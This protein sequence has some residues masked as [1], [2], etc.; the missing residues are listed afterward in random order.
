MILVFFLFVFCLFFFCVSV[1]ISWV[2]SAISV[3][4]VSS[5]GMG[6]YVSLNN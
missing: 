1:N 5:V 6:D 4:Y 2:E 3:A